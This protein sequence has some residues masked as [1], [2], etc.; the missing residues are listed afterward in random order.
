MKKTQR[1]STTLKQRRLKLVV[2]KNCL[3]RLN[4]L[5][6]HK[7]SKEAM[8]DEYHPIRPG[9]GSSNV[10]GTGRFC[11]NILMVFKENSVILLLNLFVSWCPR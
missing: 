1:F 4:G 6:I 2:L 9:F 5:S 10:L 8:K 3:V 7:F 11:M